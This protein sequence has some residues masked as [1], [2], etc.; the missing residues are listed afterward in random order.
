MATVRVPFAEVG[1]EEFNARF[2]R[3][4]GSC[5]P[6]KLMLLMGADKQGGGKGAEVLLAGNLGG[7]GEAHLKAMAAPL[8]FM[9]DYPSEIVDY[10]IA[11]T[12]NQWKF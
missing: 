11:L 4:A 7:L 9:P 12:D 10:F 5:F 6:D 8:G 2:L 3:Y 1:I